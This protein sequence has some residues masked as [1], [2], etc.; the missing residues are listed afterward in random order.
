MSKPKS[1]GCIIAGVLTIIISLALLITSSVYINQ[2]YYLRMLWIQIYSLSIY[3]LIISVFAILF[4]SG[5]I[6]VVLR[7]FPALTTL[8]SG[9][10][11]LIAFLTVISSVLLLTGRHN[12][13]ERTYKDSIVL[14][15]NY[16]DSKSTVGQIQ[17]DY[18][19]CGVDKATDWKYYYPD[20]SSTPD[21]CCVKITPHCG[22]G[23]LLTQDKIY[24]RG[25]AE[26]M[27]IHLRDIYNALISLSFLLLV[28]S[29]ASATLGIYFERFIREQYQMM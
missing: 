23:S 28:T 7:Q 15:F 4:A 3:S 14:F 18:K 13:V 9:S 22:Q 17:Q 10:L 8:F 20:N 16:S 24:L 5:F 26:P 25:C 6:Y 11:L 12:I 27:T 2:T 21:S 19:C 29:L 1:L